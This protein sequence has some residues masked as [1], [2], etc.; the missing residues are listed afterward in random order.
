[1]NCSCLYC[2]NNQYHVDIAA[3]QNKRLNGISG[4]LRVKNDAEFLAEAIDSCIDAL[5][6]LIIVYNDCSDESPQIIK[7]K[8]H[9][10]SKIKYYE[11]KPKIQQSDPQMQKFVEMCFDPASPMNARLKETL[12]Q[13]LGEAKQ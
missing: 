12:L 6:E 11:Y 1:M 13:M 5:D 8:A 4:I 10:Y 3:F 2:S 9:Q 7:E